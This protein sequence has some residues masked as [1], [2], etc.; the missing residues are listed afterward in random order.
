MINSIKEIVTNIK[1]IFLSKDKD[2]II[3]TIGDII[4]I[5]FVA[6]IIKIPMIFLKTIVLDFLNNVENTYNVQNVL[7]FLFE[8]GYIFIAFIYIYQRLKKCFIKNK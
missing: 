3:K 7:S 5:L 4:S 1:N 2:R 8:F 6:I